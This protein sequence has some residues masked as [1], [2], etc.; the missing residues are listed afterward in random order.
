MA[1]TN[2]RRAERFHVHKP[3]VTHAVRQQAGIPY[4]IE[5]RVCSRCRRLLDERQLRRAGA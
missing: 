1:D 3:V 2:L 5:Q 4:E